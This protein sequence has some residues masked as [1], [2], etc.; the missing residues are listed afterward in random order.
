M[1]HDVF[2]ALRKKIRMIGPF[3]GVRMMRNRGYTFEQAHVV[4]FGF[5]PRFA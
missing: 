5:L 4:M 2:A 1:S 3:A